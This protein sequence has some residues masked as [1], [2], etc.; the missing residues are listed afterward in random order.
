MAVERVGV[1]SL[2]SVS[3]LATHVK[4]ERKK[5]TYASIKES[6]SVSRE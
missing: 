2:G 3:Y 1:I 5:E 6:V 4:K